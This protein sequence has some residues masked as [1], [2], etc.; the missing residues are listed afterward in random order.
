MHGGEIIAFRATGCG[1]DDCPKQKRVCNNGVL[2]GEERYNLQTCPVPV[3]VPPNHPTLENVAW[4]S[5]QL[6]LTFNDVSGATSYK[7]CRNGEY[8][9]TID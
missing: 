9:K 4:Q 3:C 6:K 2:D 1:E 8:L 7:L 5:S